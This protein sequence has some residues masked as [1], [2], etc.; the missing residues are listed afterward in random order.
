MSLVSSNSSETPFSKHPLRLLLRHSFQ[1][2][3]V[4]NCLTTQALI[5]LENFLTITDI[6]KNKPLLVQGTSDME[7]YF[8]LEGVLKR[9]VTGPEGK[10]MILRFAQ[11][12]QFETTY[13]AWRLKNRAPYSIC[14]VTRARVAKCPMA[15]WVEFIN[16]H[17][18]LKHNFE[19]EVMRLMS[20]VMEH[21]TAL[22]LL[23]ATGRLE[24]FQ[25]RNPGLAE[26]LPRKDLALYL[27]IAPETLSRV[28][29]SHDH[30][31][32]HLVV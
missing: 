5:E 16:A 26:L 32:L 12:S 20:E 7:Q 2:N 25:D 10:Q 19:Y 24:R 15:L 27:N 4:L 3:V 8:I 30:H 9:V 17:Q 13:A 11:E 29:G 18:K 22:H 1:N 21:T 28:L 31:S 23:D 14:S 6:A